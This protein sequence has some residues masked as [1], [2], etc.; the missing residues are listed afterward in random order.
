MALH[1]PGDVR[2]LLEIHLATFPRLH[3][4]RCTGLAYWSRGRSHDG[5]PDDRVQRVRQALPRENAA[6]IER[7]V[8]QQ[9]IARRIADP[10]AA[11]VRYEKAERS[12]SS[13]GGAPS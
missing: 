2:R 7:A 10:I 4:R 9:K 12:Q 13:Q 1:E 3:G 11:F 5:V 6:P 8:L